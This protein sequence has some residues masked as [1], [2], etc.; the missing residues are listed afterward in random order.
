MNLYEDLQPSPQSS[1]RA[2]WPLPKVSSCRWTLAPLLFFLVYYKLFFYNISISYKWNQYVVF[3][4]G[5]FHLAQYPW[6][7]SQ[8]LHALVI[9]VYLLLNKSYQVSHLVLELPFRD[10][11]KIEINILN[12]RKLFRFSFLLCNFWQFIPFLKISHFI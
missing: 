7:S 4:L 3:I 10:C 1:F 8:L 5:F 6:D 9:H 2:I 11:L 12:I